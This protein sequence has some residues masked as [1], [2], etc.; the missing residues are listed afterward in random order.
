MLNHRAQKGCNSSGTYT[1]TQTQTH[2]HAHIHVRDSRM[3]IRP[4]LPPPA[5]TARK[6]PYAARFCQPVL[7]GGGYM[8]RAWGGRRG[9]RPHAV[10]FNEAVYGGCWGGRIV[11][12]ALSGSQGGNSVKLLSRI[13]AEVEMRLDGTSSRPFPN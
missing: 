6:I 13:S 2:A 3:Y 11:L 12:C 1:N 5:H 7:A 4:D 9:A 8:W 10:T